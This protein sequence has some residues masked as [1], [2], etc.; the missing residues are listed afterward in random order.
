MNRLDQYLDGLG[1]AEKR[2]RAGAPT[3]GAGLKYDD[4][5]ADFGMRN[6][7]LITEQ[8]QRRTQAADDIGQL[9]LV[10]IHAVAD[11]DRIVAPEDLAKVSRC[12]ELMVQPAVGDQE[13]PPAR[14]FAIDDP[15]DIDPGPRRRYSVR[16]R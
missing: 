10:V 4:Q 15:A 7:D 13:C 5:I 9:T 8:I 14:H 16:A 3:V 11:G 1:V 12:R 6:F 2:R